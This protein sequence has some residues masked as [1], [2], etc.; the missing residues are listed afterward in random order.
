MGNTGIGMEDTNGLKD[1][2][3]NLMVENLMLRVTASEIADELVK[4]VMDSAFLSASQKTEYCGRLIAL[5]GLS[6]TKEVIEGE[7]WLS[8]GRKPILLQSALAGFTSVVL[9]Y[10]LQKI[11]FALTAQKAGSNEHW[12]T[13]AL[14]ALVGLFVL[15]VGIFYVTTPT[16]EEKVLASQTGKFMAEL[17]NQLKKELNEKR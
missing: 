6:R 13:P 2:V 1:K 7:S 4:E 17:R 14:A 5:R 3:K 8:A 11:L 16:K 12:L 9:I 15:A 10:L